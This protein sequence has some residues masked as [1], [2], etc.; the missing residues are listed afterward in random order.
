[1]LWNR[2]IFASSNGNKPKLGN[3]IT[4]P[5]IKVMNTTNNSVRLIGRPGKDPEIKVFENN[6]KMARFSLAVSDRRF[7]NDQTS[8]VTYWHNIIAWGANASTVEEIVK[9][10]EKVS[11]EGKLVSRSWNDKDGNKRYSTE[12]VLNTIEKFEP[13]Q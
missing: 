8:E 12:V 11:L 1:M 7:A 13:E 3:L 9:K 4:N 6:V 10:G 5:K 2:C